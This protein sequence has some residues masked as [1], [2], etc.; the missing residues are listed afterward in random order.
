MFRIISGES[1]YLKEETVT[2]RIEKLQ[3]L[4]NEYNPDD[5]FNCD[6]TGLLYRASPDRSSSLRSV[7]AQKAKK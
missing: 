5:V 3:E 4:I 7:M 2:D 6:E 1:N